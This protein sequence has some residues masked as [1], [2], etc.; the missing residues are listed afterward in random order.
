M[1]VD[2]VVLISVT[3]LEKRQPQENYL[4][5]S[6]ALPAGSLPANQVKSALGGGNSEAQEANLEGASGGSQEVR[7]VE[8]IRLQAKELKRRADGVMFS[9]FISISSYF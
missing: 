3:D 5:K 9:R 8:D 2:Y 4:E 7:N 6:A 1:Y